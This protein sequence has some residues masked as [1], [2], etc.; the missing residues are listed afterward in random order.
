M[1]PI[2]CIVGPTACGKHEAALLVAERLGC[3]IISVDSMKVYRGLDI[4]TAKPSPEALRRVPHHL[5][6][7]CDP[8]ESY[9][10]GRFVKD[11]RALLARIPRPML[12][13]GTFLYYK[14]LVYG[15]FEGPEADPELRRQLQA[16]ARERGLDALYQELKKVDP[17]TRIHPHDEKR[18][19]R[20]LEVYRLTGRPF[21]ELHTHFGARPQLNVRA[22]CLVRE[23]KELRERCERRIDRMM[24]AGFMDEVQRLRGRPL[25]REVRNSIGYREMLDVLEGRLGLPPALDQLKKRTWVFAR[26]QMTWIRSLKELTPVD[27]TGLLTPQAIAEKLLREVKP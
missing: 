19:L 17:Q 3:E 9:N 24:Q 8:H 10:A 16:E 25:S 4:G 11:A 21:S 5:I 27:V 22:L 6:D 18:I 7:I 2:L 26:K 14:A 12:V 1:E 20:A 13:G 23:M 15:M